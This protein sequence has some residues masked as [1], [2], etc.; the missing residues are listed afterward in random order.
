VQA[1]ARLLRLNGLAITAAIGGVI[2]TCGGARGW[3]AA[4]LTLASKSQAEHARAEVQKLYRE[5]VHVRSCGEVVPNDGSGESEWRCSV[6]APRCNRS[7]LFVLV[8]QYAQYAAS[9]ATKTGAILNRPCSVP[10]DR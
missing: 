5:E 9:P 8:H 6:V 7:Y 1:A 10:S 4:P 3:V 2:I